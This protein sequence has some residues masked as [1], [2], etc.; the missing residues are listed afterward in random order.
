MEMSDVGVYEHSPTDI[1]GGDR[2]A[3]RRAVFN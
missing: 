3:P 2:Y 1:I